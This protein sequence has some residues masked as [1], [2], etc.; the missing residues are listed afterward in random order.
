MI[1]RSNVIH[2]AGW[3]TCNNKKFIIIII[4]L[5]VCMVFACLSW[6]VILYAAHWEK[7]QLLV[8]NPLHARNK[9]TCALSVQLVFIHRQMSMKMP[10][11]IIIPNNIM[12]AVY[13]F[14]I[15]QFYR[16][17]KIH[18]DELNENK[19]QIHCFYNTFACSFHHFFSVLWS[20][21]IKHV[22]NRKLLCLKRHI[23]PV[24]VVLV[25]HISYPM[26]FLHSLKLRNSWENAR[27]VKR[28]WQQQ[29]F[30]RNK[31]II[32]NRHLVCCMGCKKHTRR[33]TYDSC[34]TR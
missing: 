30:R 10:F 13:S 24:D 17:N 14:F 12:N 6:S 28:R 11:N 21:Y 22:F 32:I 5:H 29:K 8:G 23:H 2:M 18:R 15:S 34:D 27:A 9:L 19:V 7:H 4:S 33:H 16:L 25:E 26:I 20:A 3:S 1:I 31:I